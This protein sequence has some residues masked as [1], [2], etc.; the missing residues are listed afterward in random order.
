MQIG[1]ARVSTKEQSLDLQVDALRKVGCEKVYR[2][3]VSGAKAER[4]V[5][6]ALL[7]E[8]RPADVTWSSDFGHPS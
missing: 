5:L 3:V 7:R 2:E 1:Y 4:P 8:L 6:D